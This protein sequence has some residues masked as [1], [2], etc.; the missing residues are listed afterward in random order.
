MNYNLLGLIIQAASGEKYSDYV[1]THIFDPLDRSHLHIK[2]RRQAK[3]NEFRLHI[4]VWISHGCAQSAGARRFAVF[5]TDHL[6]CERHGPL[7]DCP[8]E[9]GKVR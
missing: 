3:W 6:Q 7:P 8:I 9:W 2:G 5:R 1:Q 4:L